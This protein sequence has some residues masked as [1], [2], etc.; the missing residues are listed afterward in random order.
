VEGKIIDT[1]Y[2]L[3]PLLGKGGMG[4]V[5]QAQHQGTLRHVALKLIRKGHGATT[6]EALRRFRREA[7]AIGSLSSPHI[8]QVL[9]AGEDKTTGD[10]YLVME[11]LLGE[12]LE[13]LVARGGPLPEHVALRIAGQA[14]TGL[15][16][17]HEAGIIHRDL[18]PANVFLARQDDGTLTVKLLDFGLAKVLAS[19]A[20][21]PSSDSLT[22]IGAMLGSPLY[23]SPEQVENSKDVDTRTDI[24]SFASVLYYALIGAAPHEHI[25]S[26]GKLLISICTSPVQP[27]RDRAPQVSP[28]LAQV[29]HEALAI[30]P[31]RRTPSA[32]AMLASMKRLAVDGFALPKEM[33]PSL[34]RESQPA[35]EPRQAVIAVENYRAIREDETTHL[36]ARNARGAANGQ[37]NSKL[38]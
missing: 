14:L 11:R 36:D 31:A 32:A 20:N 7:R 33:L 8:V 1:K 23:M 13:R 28:E 6:P 19:S 29:V 12:D 16:C 9:D 3:G 5:Y 24:W 25:S 34:P 21:A 4:A 15:V 30:D 17:A 18:K 22:G 35:A 10:P 2:L 26:L 38:T 27:L 37:A